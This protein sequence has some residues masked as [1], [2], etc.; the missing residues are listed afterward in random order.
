MNDIKLT[1]IEKARQNYS[2]IFPCG[3]KADLAECFTVEA[4][5]IFFWFNT[6]DETTHVLSMDAN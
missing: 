2:R 5:R 4:N 1:M 6:E 3:L